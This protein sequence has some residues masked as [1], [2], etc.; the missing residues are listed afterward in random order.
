MLDGDAHL[1]IVSA[2][3]VALYTAHFAQLRDFYIET[4]DLA[5]SHPAE[6]GK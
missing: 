5:D 3:H 4:L 1:R 2:H 6:G